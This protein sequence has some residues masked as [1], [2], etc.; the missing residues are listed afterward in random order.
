MKKFVAFIAA[1][2]VFSIT[3]HSQDSVNSLKDALAGKY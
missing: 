1:F 2:I 3:A